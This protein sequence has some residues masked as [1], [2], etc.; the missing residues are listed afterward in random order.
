MTT[1][2]QMSIPTVRQ[3]VSW[4]DIKRRMESQKNE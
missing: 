1:E 2:K 4:V 3:R